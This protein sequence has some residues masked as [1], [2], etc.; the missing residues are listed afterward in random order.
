[1]PFRIP[2]V[3]YRDGDIDVEWFERATWSLREQIAVR[4]G[5]LQSQ[6]IR[7]CCVDQNPVGF[8][9]AVTRRLPRA[10]EGVVTVFPRKAVASRESSHDHLQFPKVLAPS[11]HQLHVSRELR[12][13]RDGLHFSQLSN[14]SSSE[15]NT[16]TS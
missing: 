3:W 10:S 11:S 6:R 1:M 7:I 5:S 15:S 14:I 9:V 13:L 4:T 16:S 12:R 8:N 2:A